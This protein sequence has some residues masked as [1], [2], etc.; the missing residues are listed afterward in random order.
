MPKQ[1]TTD[2]FE[3]GVSGAGSKWQDR[4]EEAA[5]EGRYGTGDDGEENY[6]ENAGSSESDSKY[7]S[8]VAASFGLDEDEIS[9]A[10]SD[11]ID[12][13]TANDWAN[14]VRGASERWAE[15]VKSTSASE[16]EEKTS[17]ASSDWLQNTKEGL[18]GE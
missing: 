18:R 10:P 4:V 12:S 14:G 7:R 16:W 3:D 2:G 8:N 11:G 1:A 5:E 15:G 9:A 13:D 17:D 6:A